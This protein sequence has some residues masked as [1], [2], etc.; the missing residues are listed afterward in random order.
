MAEIHSTKLLTLPDGSY[1]ELR[2]VPADHEDG[3]SAELLTALQQKVSE[4]ESDLNTA[5]D[6]SSD[7]AS[8][9]EGLEVDTHEIQRAVAR[10]VEDVIQDTGIENQSD[11]E[12]AIG[13]ATSAIEAAQSTLEEIETLLKEALAKPTPDPAADESEGA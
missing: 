2:V 13:S 1:I 3:V 12:D 10:S 8:E 6:K 9:V 11:A 5:V 4:L 7:A